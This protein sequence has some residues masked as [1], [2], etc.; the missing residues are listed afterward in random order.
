MMRVELGTLEATLAAA[1]KPSRILPSTTTV[2]DLPLP[3]GTTRAF[4][5]REAP[6]MAPGLASRYPEI[7]TYK[8]TAIGDP[9]TTA[10]LDLTPHGFHAMVFSPAGT[11]YIDPDAAW[12]TS[13]RSARL[14]R[15]YFKRD[16]E[17]TDA[18]VLDRTCHFG[19]ELARTSSVLPSL[20]SADA[21]AE[22][23]RIPSGSEL[24][25]Y[26]LAIAATAEYTS[27]HGGTVPLALA[28]IVT[29]VNRVNGIYERELAITMTL[30][31]NNDLIIY[32]N[33]GTDPYTNNNGSVMLGQNQSN[34]DAVILATNYDI[35]H[36]FS[37]GGGGVATLGVPCQSGLEARGVT[38][39]ASPV[40]DSFYVDFVAHEMG[41]QFG[42]NHTFNGTAGNCGGGNRNGPTA[43]EP[44]SG[45]TVMA[46][47]GICSPQN[48]QSNSD[49][50]FHSQSFD[51]IRNY[52]QLGAGDTCPTTT[53]TAND[54]PVVDAGTGGFSIPVDTPFTLTG[55]AIDPNGHP[56]VYRWEEFDLG[57]AGAPNSPSGD[58]PLFR[59]F[60]AT[61]SPAR[62]FPQPSDLLNNAQTM[63]ELLPS[64]GRNLSFRLT[65]LDNQAGGGG[66]D[67][68][69]LAFSVTAGA[70]PFLVTAPNTAIAALGL[71]PLNVTWDIA[72]TTAAPVSCANV[73]IRF[74][75]DGGLTFGTTLAAATP[76]DGAHSVT[77]PNVATTTARIQVACSDNVFFDLS[78]VDFGVTE[79]GD[80]GFTIDATPLVR[81]ICSGDP[82]DYTI[83]V[84]SLVGFVD[85]VD[86]SV[87][88]IPPSAAGAF[89]VDPV[90]PP[91]SSTLQVTTPGSLASGTYPL[92]IE[93][94]SGIITK[95][96]DVDLVVSSELPTTPTLLL[97]AVGATDE[98]VTPTLSWTASTGA[99]TYTVEIATDA[100]FSTI[101]YSASEA[102]TS[103]GV[104]STLSPATGYFWRVL[105]E[106]SCG[107][108]LQAN[109][110]F[111]TEPALSSCASPA[112]AIPDGTGSPLIDSQI[113]GAAG[114]ITDLD[115]S[116]DISHPFVGDLQATL[117]HVGNATT[118]ALIN[119][120]G[121][122]LIDPTFGCGGDDIDAVLDDEGGSA[123]EDACEISAPALGGHLTPIA[124][125]STFDGFDSATTWTLN[126]ADVL[127]PDPGTLNAWCLEISYATPSLPDSDGDGVP[128]AIDNCP[129]DPNPDQADPFGDGAG[130]PCDLDFDID[131]LPNDWEA[132]FGLDPNDPND[133]ALDADG[134]GLSNLDEFWLGTDPTDPLSPSP[135]VALPTLSPFATL[136][137]AG[138]LVSAPTLIRRRKSGLER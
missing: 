54:A 96:A 89:T 131:G 34:L 78:D 29:A 49:D 122:P 113:L 93:G 128:D 95:T 51:E 55:S 132:V 44:G 62:T 83:D 10:Q 92:E 63:G 35:G 59:S 18:A 27:F 105:A 112:L 50:Y 39:Q 46:Y 126:V 8:G 94:Q 11:I 64:Y 127:N 1:R 19:D 42:A 6:I 36:V 99:E 38:G 88:G 115:V 5:V 31:A 102:T 14:Y 9:S 77:V 25:E 138:V 100:A 65:A 32:T 71:D 57:P 13:Q 23:V 26:R 2:L 48:I 58:A 28:A 79:T 72:N 108:A 137:L 15:A 120:P 136:I 68:D 111:V 97:P 114:T 109:A 66:V 22:S 17:P 37:T 84:G 80:P 76:N 103:H 4:L 107:Q 134:D 12:G 30:V 117:E 73:D 70:G 104:A 86:L 61:T 16:A 3:D 52:S 60:P 130:A 110:S 82:T 56:L 20:P 101:V 125:L 119:R 90:V 91:G 133:A 47:A 116:I 41:H 7:R 74:S 33:P 121:L 123:A 124:P 67:Y 98:I 24:R 69:T 129:T 53:V 106:N 21:E 43:Y 40:G 85:P 45:T 118:V 75:D 81:S 135:G 87:T